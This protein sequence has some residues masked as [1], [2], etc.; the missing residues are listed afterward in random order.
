MKPRLKLPS[1]SKVLHSDLALAVSCHSLHT[2]LILA[3]VSGCRCLRMKSRTSEW[4]LNLEFCWESVLVIP[5][6]D[7]NRAVPSLL[8]E[9]WIAVVVDDLEAN[10]L[11]SSTWRSTS[12]SLALRNSFSWLLELFSCLRSSTSVIRSYERF[13]DSSL[14]RRRIRNWS[15][16]MG[17]EMRVTESWSFWVSSEGGGWER[18]P[19]NRKEERWERIEEGDSRPW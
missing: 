11:R 16:S 14:E 6:K 9:E 12:V 13:Q 2:L 5:F 8:T 7:P 3:I 17:G 1:R 4:R 10:V 18:W 15:I 19:W